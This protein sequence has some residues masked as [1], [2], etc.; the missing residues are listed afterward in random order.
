MNEQK[1]DEAL[2]TIPA[3]PPM[4]DALRAQTREAAAVTPLA[5]AESRALLA[6]MLAFAA[7]LG[8]AAFLRLGPRSDAPWWELAPL[9]AASIAGIWLALR[10]AIPGRVPAPQLWLP[11]LLAPIAFAAI[12]LAVHGLGGDIG[13]VACLECGIG[14]SVVPALLVAGFVARAF[15]TSPTLSGT[16]AGTSAGLLG[17]ALLQLHCPMTTGPHLLVMHDGVALIAAALGAAT[18]LRAG[19]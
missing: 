18:S 19:R 4:S 3:T 11:V 14:V 13:P 6:V 2:R 9:L 1:I 8:G 16:L 15:P 7:A 17:I 5:S 10:S 12:A